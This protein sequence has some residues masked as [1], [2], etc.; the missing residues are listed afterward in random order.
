MKSY[1]ELDQSHCGP[2]PTAI[3]RA[4]SSGKSSLGGSRKA[5][6]NCCPA[7]LLLG[8]VVVASLLPAGCASVKPTEYQ[9][10]EAET[11]PWNGG[12]QPKPDYGWA[13]GVA[14]LLEMLVR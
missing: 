2:M 6:R 1:R 14:G 9:Q 7:G 11:R 13:E 12:S 5:H 4:D 3:E 10:S 8:L